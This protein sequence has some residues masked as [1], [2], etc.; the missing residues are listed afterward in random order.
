MHCEAPNLLWVISKKCLLE[1]VY[2]KPRHHS[3]FYADSIYYHKAD[4][5]K[6]G[7][8]FIRTSFICAFNFNL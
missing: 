2:R 6:L 7:D 4:I 1:L 3:K 8:I 5:N